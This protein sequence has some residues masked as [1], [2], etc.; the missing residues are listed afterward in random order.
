MKFALVIGLLCIPTFADA[1][2]AFR[3][4]NVPCENIRAAVKIYGLGQVTSLAK[5]LK[6]PQRQIRLAKKCLKN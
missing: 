4:S 1:R 3:P 6:I 5:E 2:I